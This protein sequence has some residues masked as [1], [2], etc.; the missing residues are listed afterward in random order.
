MDDDRTKHCYKKQKDGC[1]IFL[2]NHRFY[3]RPFMHSPA[4]YAQTRL[5]GIFHA[6]FLFP[7]MI[8]FAPI[9]SQIP[10][11]ALARLKSKIIVLSI[12]TKNKRMAVRF[13]C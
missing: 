10:M 12:V 1:S 9:M 7:S 13:F 4:G 11:A 2:L 5:A 6:L 8:I 3:R